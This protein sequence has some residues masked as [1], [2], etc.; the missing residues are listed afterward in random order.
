MATLAEKLIELRELRVPDG[1]AW[2][3][4]AAGMGHVLDAIEAARSRLVLK[5]ELE[6]L[7]DDYLRVYGRQARR[8][9]DLIRANERRLA[10]CRRYS[11]G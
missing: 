10:R 11:S 1:V 9:R 2:D 6:V 5:L 7:L 8:R 3:L 4:R